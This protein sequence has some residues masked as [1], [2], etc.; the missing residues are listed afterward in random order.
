[1]NLASVSAYQCP[2]LNGLRVL[3]VDNN[4]DCIEL[5]RILLEEFS[6]LVKIATSV[7]EALEL[8]THW[9]ADVLISDIAIPGEDG[10][11][12]IRKIRILEKWNHL[13]PLP[14]IAMTAYISEEGYSQALESGY[15][16]Y[17]EKPF[18]LDEL[19]TTVAHLAG[20][21]KQRAFKPIVVK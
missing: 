18:D 3:I 7:K 8:L 14:A 19:V 12:L 16:V 2:S 17:A 11:S 4:R 1:M 13:K 10:Y 9:E 21:N 20:A 6:V 5:I 15:Q